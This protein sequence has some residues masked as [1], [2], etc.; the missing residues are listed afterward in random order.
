MQ[1][2]QCSRPY[3][4]VQVRMAAIRP[5]QILGARLIDEQRLVHPYTF[6]HQLNQRLR[7]EQAW[8]QL[9]K[10]SSKESDLKRIFTRASTSCTEGVCKPTRAWTC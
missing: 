1:A 6:S 10:S 8:L 3:L 7:P 5:A 2:N 9:A 4:C